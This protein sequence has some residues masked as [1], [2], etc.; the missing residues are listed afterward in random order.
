MF[1]EISQKSQENTCARDSF[2]N[3]VT[4]L[5]PATLLKKSLWHRCFPVDFVKFL[6]TPFLKNTSGRLPL[7]VWIF[8][9]QELF[10]KGT[11][12]SSII[13]KLLNVQLFSRNTSSCV[14]RAHLSSLKLMKH[15]K[16]MSVIKQ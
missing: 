10:N 6:R 9:S 2:F 4:G 14:R 13:C 3:K 15:C 8:Y 12:L 1:L 5:R 7:V 16:K 11:V